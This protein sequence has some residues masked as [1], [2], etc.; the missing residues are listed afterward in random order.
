M[1]EAASVILFLSYALLISITKL[2]GKRPKRLT[3]G[4]ETSKSNFFLR[5]GKDDNGGTSK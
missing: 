5:K 4:R 3:C 1:D 2:V